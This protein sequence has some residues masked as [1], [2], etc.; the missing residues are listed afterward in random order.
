MKIQPDFA[1]RTI[2]RRSLSAPIDRFVHGVQDGAHQGRKLGHLAGASALSLALPLGAAYAGLL[3]SAPVVTAVALSPVGLVGGL[4][5]ASLAERKLGIGQKLGALAGG[6]VGGLVGLFRPEPAEGWKPVELPSGPATG[7][8]EA[9]FPALLHKFVHRPRNATVEIAENLGATATTVLLGGIW[10][11]QV[12][13]GLL[14]MPWSLVFATVAGPALGV[15]A[16]GVLENALGLGRAAGELVGHL[17]PEVHPGSPGPDSAGKKAFF[18][19]AQIIAEPIVS[20]MID[21]T[22]ITNR[23]FSESPR[24]TTR[25]ASHPSPEVNDERLLRNFVSLA[26]I[27]GV[28]GQE[29]AVGRE[30]KRRLDALGIGYQE[31][32]DGTLIGTLPGTVK[33]APTLVLAA[34]QDT[35]APTS[36]EAIRVDERR[37]FTDGTHILGSD[38][39]AGLAQ[40]LEAV[41]VVLADGRPRPELKLVFTVSEETGLTGAGRLEPDELTTRPGLGLV[42]D[43]TDVR[44][45]NLTNDA[46]LVNPGRS[47]RYQFAQEEPVVQLAMA[48]MAA[49]GTRPRPL[50]VPIMTGA[51]T[52][53]NTRAFQGPNLRTIAIGCGQRDIHTPHENISRADLSAVARTLVAAVSRTTDFQVQGQEIVSRPAGPAPR[54]RE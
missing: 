25:F 13:A 54:S 53:A 8:H 40:I 4:V 39:R 10:L 34:H 38:N 33:D 9:P 44:D 43:S 21:A 47:V 17:L 32:P 29:A 31:K 22:R 35:V 19:V 26:G 5:L 2:V 20:T 42:V 14:P 18:K 41:E 30:L 50:R 36:A 23:L 49:G 15:V 11:P 3:V 16:G 37:V 45:L 27:E 52:D 46:V 6:A 1:S 51:G 48:S 7:V 12:A 28:S 24:L